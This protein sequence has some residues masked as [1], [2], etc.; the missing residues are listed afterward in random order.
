MLS[1]P[2]VA[3]IVRNQ[4]EQDEMLGDYD[5]PKQLANV[6]YK[7][8]KVSIPTQVEEGWEVSYQY[9]TM[10][11]AEFN[12]EDPDNLT[13]EFLNRKTLILN[14][15]GGIVRA[16]EKITSKTSMDTDSMLLSMDFSE[17]E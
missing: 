8:E 16:G 2:E 17:E 9:R 15:K 11:T 7:L 13:K 6:S 1:R 4:I 14:D 5:D 12:I 3:K 10:V